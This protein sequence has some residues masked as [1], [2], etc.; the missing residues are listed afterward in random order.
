MTSQDDYRGLGKGIRKGCRYY[1]VDGK[2]LDAD[3]NAS[4][5]IAKRYSKHLSSFF[6]AMDG[7]YK[8]R[9]Q[10]SVNSPIAGR[11]KKSFLQA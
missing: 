10:G 7:S 4:C 3:G 5:N 8:P 9:K 2:V 6:P 11:L 1:A